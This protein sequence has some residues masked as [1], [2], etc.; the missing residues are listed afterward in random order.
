MK[1]EFI[2]TNYNNA[3]LN[4]FEVSNVHKLKQHCFSPKHLQ[5]IQSPIIVGHV[6]TVTVNYDR[7]LSLFHH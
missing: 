1:N 5:Q 2:S 6:L 4:T 3:F 7:T